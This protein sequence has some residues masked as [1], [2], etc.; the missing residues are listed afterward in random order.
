VKNALKKSVTTLVTQKDK[1]LRKK[2]ILKL[3]LSISQLS[4]ACLPVL[5]GP[6]DL[7]CTEFKSYVLGS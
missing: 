4:F 2:T 5:S 1:E 7:F 6:V 3:F